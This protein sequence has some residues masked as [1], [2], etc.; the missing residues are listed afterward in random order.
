M[1][2]V[3]VTPSTLNTLR[4]TMSEEDIK[5][6]FAHR[7][8]VQDIVPIVEPIDV[9]AIYD[10]SVPVTIT[11]VED[12]LNVMHAKYM[13]YEVTPIIE[14]IDYDDQ[15][16]TTPPAPAVP[17]DSEIPNFN[18]LEMTTASI[19]AFMKAKTD[20]GLSLEE[21]A[22]LY[23]LEYINSVHRSPASLEACKLYAG[24]KQRIDAHEEDPLMS[25]DIGVNEIV[26]DQIAAHPKLMP[27]KPDHIKYLSS[28]DP[29]VLCKYLDTLGILADSDIH[30]QTL[31][32]GVTQA[33]GFL[34][35]KCAFEWITKA[36]S[37]A[38]HMAR[39][40]ELLEKI[41]QKIINAFDFVASAVG[42]FTDFL[43]ALKTK[44]I[45]M[46][47]SVWEKL[48]DFGEHFFYIIPMFCTFFL[49]TTAS[50]L[51]NKFLAL[52]APQY[53]FSYSTIFQLIVACCAMVGFAEMASALISMS[54]TSRFTF[55]ALIFN[56]Q[57]VNL[58]EEDP[59]FQ[60][61]SRDIQDLGVTE[62]GGP[63]VM[64]F[65]GLLSLLT[66]FAP[67]NMKCDLYEMAKWS[68]GLK[69]LGD[70]YDKFSS[71]AERVAFWL[72]E[73]VGLSNTWDSGA[74]QSILLSTGIRFQ[75]W[76]AEV[77]S[78][79]SEII[80]S[81]NLQS[82]ITRVRRLKEQGDKLQKFMSNNPTAISFMLRE[83]LKS[84]LKT[85]DSVVAR[86]ERALD[87]DGSRICPFS[88]L[89]TGAPAA[90][91]S[92]TM[93][94]FI[95]DV[96]NDMDEPS[97]GRIYPR[98]SGDQYWTH[99]LRQTAV[100][101]DEFAQNA[102]IPGKSDEMELIPLVSCNHYPLNCAAI[103]D[104]GI[105]F[106]SKYIFMC[107]NKADVSAGAGLADNDAFR[108]RRHL[109]VKVVRDDRPFNPSEPY[110][111]QTFQLLDPLRPHTNLRVL[112]PEGVM[113]EVGPMSY[114]ELCTYTVNKMREHFQKEE[115][116]KNFSDSRKLITKKTLE[117]GSKFFTP[118]TLLSKKDIL[119]NCENIKGLDLV[120]HEVYHDDGIHI[121]FDQ[122]GRK[123]THDLSDYEKILYESVSDDLD[124]VQFEHALAIELANSE[125]N[126]N[127]IKGLLLMVEPP[128]SYVKPPKA[129]NSD[130]QSFVDEVWEKLSDK[131]RFLICA[132]TRRQAIRQ[133]G[134]VGRI[135]KLKDDMMS[136][137]VV[138]T[139][140]KIPFAMKWMLGI[141]AIFSVGASAMWAL[142]KLLNMRT[143]NPMEMIGVFMGTKALSAVFE[144]SYE[145][146]GSNE[147]AVVYKHRKIRAY[148]QGSTTQY[149]T[150]SQNDCEKLEAIK[151]A[152]GTLICKGLGGETRQVFVL[153]GKDHYLFLTTHEM[154]MIDFSKACTLCM[155]NDTS[156][157]LFLH[158]SDVVVGMKGGLKDPICAIR[159][160]NVYN[161]PRAC[162][163]SISFDFADRLEGM[164]DCFIQPHAGK[165][166]DQNV[167]KSTVTRVHEVVD[168]LDSKDRLSW[169]ASNLLKVP[170]INF[171]GLCGRLLVCCDQS[172]DLKVVGMHVSGNVERGKSQS[173]FAEFNGLHGSNTAVRQQSDEVDFFELETPLPITEMV[174]Q[175]GKVGIGQQVKLVGK[176][177]IVKSSIHDN[178]WR[179]PETE[180]T[181]ISK[182]DPR[183]PQP[184]DPYQAGI[185]KFVKE[186][187]PL[188]FSVGSDESLV[189]RDIREELGNQVRMEGGFALSTVLSDEHTINGVDGIDFAERLIMST[190]EGYPYVLDRQ[191][192]E[193]GKW[194][195][196]DQ[197]GDNWIMKDTT[198]SEMDNLENMVKQ[199]DF[200]GKIITIACAKDEKTK[201]KKIYET[202]K[203]RIFEILPYHYNLLV[204]KYFLFFMQFLMSVHDILP[205]KVGLNVYSKSWDEMYGNHARFSNHF[206]GDYS[207]F[208]T[209]TPRALLI[210]LAHMISDLANDGAEARTV[211]VNLMNLAVD[212][213]IIVGSDIF[214]VRG[215]TPSG[216]SLTVIVNSLVNQFYL[217]MA[218]RKIV[219]PISASMAP[220]RVMKSHVTFSVYGDDNVVSFDN[221]VRDYYN[222]ETIAATLKE[223]NIFLSDGKKTGVL[224]P[225]TDIDNIDFLKR[226]WVLDSNYGFRCPL[227]KSSIE[228]RLYWI[229]K[230]DDNY[231]NLSDNVHS[232]LMEAF[233]HGE[234]YFND[235]RAKIINAYEESN[236][237]C[238]IL[239][240]YEEA[241]DIWIEQRNSSRINAFMLG[242]SKEHLPA[243]VNRDV[244]RT[245]S[246]TVDVTSVKGYN[247]K[248]NSGYKRTKVFISPTLR[249]CKATF[250]AGQYEV[251]PITKE[252]IGLIIKDLSH[253]DFPLCFV[254]GDGGP[255]VVALAFAY[256]I[257][258]Q[259]L[260]RIG[261]VHLM[262]AFSKDDRE[263]HNII[264]L[265]NGLG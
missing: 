34:G 158:A 46:A 93:R 197:D 33:V 53:C 258:K 178:L 16:E 253:I 190:S 129:K 12:L 187:G 97:V 120:D 9:E 217:M 41:F 110:Y 147:Q 71:M 211:R 261:A 227:D 13:A 203:T 111:N 223:Y 18:I 66:L 224:I 140:D 233:H 85:I 245:V 228:E 23:S 61:A 133:M 131:A 220:Y 209:G 262:T 121:C 88:V 136:W 160:S 113:E 230:S 135:K 3:T 58:A 151:S 102:P 164:K 103:E 83:R 161:T 166:F 57:G 27:V 80:S 105:S 235:L 99:Y 143:W 204:R 238:P 206:N 47:I 51:I 189:L 200:D 5:C 98:N 128:K 144:Q 239:L 62:Q 52:V 130:V 104:K 48:Q 114:H 177:A 44:V 70:G 94:S 249:G 201:L 89:F 109:C 194:R 74:I 127:D 196:F 35:V 7:V 138:Q 208:D 134:V 252:N 87:L 214:H 24:V 210:K 43:S 205:C 199:K 116:S 22:T 11:S 170:S 123:C 222:L 132:V 73:K 226:R 152:Q 247:S 56:V 168:V 141:I 32:E 191:S 256:A 236:L 213:R 165:D 29:N 65:F 40:S 79:N 174:D 63:S 260:T 162:S 30:E 244:V 171:E 180:P 90:G 92:N 163:K 76:C 237:G 241:L 142:N 259:E 125:R 202:P 96:L 257:S 167:I 72:Y 55:L 263:Y 198:K 84:A 49:V 64:S 25:E 186:V 182:F 21:A 67:H 122:E 107:S 184:F 172:P 221:Q 173:F 54:K 212:R 10:P 77:E 82:D 101:Y 2:L 229:K 251:P 254:S 119:S 150:L 181:I 15:D 243:N 137:K 112:S 207:G 139:W 154:N 148:Q 17:E 145:G 117:Q 91:K 246:K 28:R 78:L 20:A 6:S 86:F 19:T 115:A 193:S 225:W 31:M 81:M 4:K 75:A 232:A 219:K 69:S 149:A 159:V 60:Q 265:F 242:V 153:V 169:K 240:H 216:F 188:D 146:S 95:Q 38:G 250:R 156:Y 215:G 37:M 124:D 195:Y 8:G 59:A 68:Q 175:I 100:F 26:L 179:K 36:K 248:R 183:S 176:T 192:G 185:R 118:F 264:S 106:N 39:A 108:R 218:W 50:F 45:D 255:A 1:Y 126:M 234:L 157:S 14:D 42:S 231:E 155:R